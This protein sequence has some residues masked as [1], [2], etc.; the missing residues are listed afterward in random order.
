MTD[1]R[2]EIARRV[3]LEEAA[4]EADL[5]A[6]GANCEDQNDFMR[7]WRAACVALG[8]AI[9]AKA[10]AAG[11]VATRAW[12]PTHRHVKSGGEYRLIGKGF[13]EASALIITTEMAI[14]V[15]QGGDFWVRPLAE[16]EDGRFEVITP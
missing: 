7:G 1:K 13:L 14:Y 9:R 8:V 10:P 2:E 6:S 16:F 15:N 3:V 4:Q 5:A 11:D 12:Q